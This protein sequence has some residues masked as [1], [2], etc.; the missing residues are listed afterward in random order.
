MTGLAPGADVMFAPP[1]PPPPPRRNRC[2]EPSDTA[3]AG[4]AGSSA[5]HAPFA[6]PS[7][8]G[9]S[10]PSR[11]RPAVRQGAVGP[12]AR[13]A[14]PRAP[15]PGFSEAARWR[16]L[17]AAGLCALP[18]LAA[19]ASS[20]ADANRAGAVAC[21]GVSSTGPIGGLSVGAARS[22]AS[23][24]PFVFLGVD[25]GRRAGFSNR[26]ERSRFGENRGRI[27]PASAPRSLG[28]VLPRRP[29]QPPGFDLTANA[30]AVGVL[31]RLPVSWWRPPATSLAARRKP[32]P[33]ACREPSGGLGLPAGGR[34]RPACCASGFRRC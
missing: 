5:A 15:L 23:P 24:C 1:P 18:I 14:A 8:S 12:F 30:G 4:R 26:R 33:G 13:H 27:R 9:K 28:F 2:V 3:P 29:L 31:L 32:V 10:A 19:P 6:P 20:H 34:G 16:S 7:V 11:P 22:I 25:V 21:I 17:V